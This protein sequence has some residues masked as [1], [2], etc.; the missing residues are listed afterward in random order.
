MGGKRFIVVVVSALIIAG[1]VIANSHAA[2]PVPGRFCKTFDFG[3]KV[4]TSKCVLVKCKEDGSRTRWK[5][6][7]FRN[8]G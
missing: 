2:D 7:K 1:S 4:T 3:K 8:F 5:A 6:I